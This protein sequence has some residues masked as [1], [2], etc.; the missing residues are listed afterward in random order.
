M[1]P[2]I[3]TIPMYPN[4][5]TIILGIYCSYYPNVSPKYA[6]HLASTRKGCLQRSPG[7]SAS[8]DRMAAP[9]AEIQCT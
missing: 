9:G 1:Y 3:C 7:V 2:N 8:A 5:F 6:T 4:I